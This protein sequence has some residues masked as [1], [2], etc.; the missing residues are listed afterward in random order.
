MHETAMTLQPAKSRACDV[1]TLRGAGS[2]GRLSVLL[3]LATMSTMILVAVVIGKLLGRAT[4]AD[5]SVEEFFVDHRTPMWNSVTH[6]FSQVADTTTVIVIGLVALVTGLLRK[7]RNGLIILAVGLI[8][9][10][11]MFL[12]ITALV[13]RPRPDVVRLDGAPPTSSFPSGHT[14]ATV[15]LWGSLAIVAVRAE[16][17]QWLQRIMLVLAFAVPLLV[18]LSRIYRGMHH[19]T[20]VVASIVLGVLWLAV[21]A[22]LFPVRPPHRDQAV[23]A[24][25]RD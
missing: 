14:F 21:L 20:D 12:A 11:L 23:A 13:S 17:R 4:G 1:P 22:R 9:E 16:W 15:V 18:G 2:R 25:R 19:P 6:L 7:I 3:V 10:V 8:A 24:P 5:R